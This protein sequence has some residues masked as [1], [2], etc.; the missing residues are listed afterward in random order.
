MKEENTVTEIL[1]EAGCLEEGKKLYEK[2]AEIFP[3]IPERGEKDEK[4]E[5]SK[6]E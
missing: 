1:K 3:E 4:S 2:L 6:S 5:K